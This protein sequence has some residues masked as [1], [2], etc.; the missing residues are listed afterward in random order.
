MLSLEAQRFLDRL[1]RRKGKA[2]S[3]Q[4]PQEARAYVAAQFKLTHKKPSDHLKVTDIVLRHHDIETP[5]RFYR[6]HAQELPALILYFHGGGFVAGNCDYVDSLCQKLADL[7]QAL[8]ISVDYHLAP[9]YPFPF[10]VHE[11]FNVLKT[12]VVHHQEYR[13]DPAKITLMGDSAGANFAAVITNMAF[14]EIPLYAQVLLYPTTDFAGDYPS[15]HEFS[16][17]YFLSK[18]DTDWAKRHY[19][20]DP[21][22][23]K[24]PLASPIFAGSLQGLPKTL[25]IT[26]ETD[27]LRDEG[28]AYA[29]HLITFGNEVH[30]HEYAGMIHCFVTFIDVFPQG[31]G[32]ALQEVKNFLAF[33][34]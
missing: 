2:M 28:R 8:V 14:K 15:L 21:H 3:E 7:T 1:K 25:I 22:Q 18:A 24:D 32:V 4:T 30:Y 29:Q 20:A 13:F 9:E 23:A 10:G 12:L 17:G 31:G 5:L 11:G 26:A 34:E 16:E 6:P 27:P 33:R 19:L